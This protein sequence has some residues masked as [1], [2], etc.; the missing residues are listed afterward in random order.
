MDKLLFPN[1]PKKIVIKPLNLKDIKTKTIAPVY[2]TER[3]DLIKHMLPTGFDWVSRNTEL[4]SK[5]HIYRS[6]NNN[7]NYIHRK[8]PSLNYALS[9]REVTQDYHFK[10]PKK[11]KNKIKMMIIIFMK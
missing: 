4:S 5:S 2:N 10:F 9:N 6:K 11:R 8:A 7:T 3:Q 1:K